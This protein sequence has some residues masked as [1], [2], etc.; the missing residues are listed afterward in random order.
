VE[1]TINRVLRAASRVAPPLTKLYEMLQIAIGAGTE[2]L[3]KAAK[4]IRLQIHPD[5]CKHQHATSATQAFN[6]VW[7]DVKDTPNP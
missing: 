3:S 7:D 6:R 1:T 5:K 4:R 2:E